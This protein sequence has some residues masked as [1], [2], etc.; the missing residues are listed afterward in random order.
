[1]LA[2]RLYLEFVIVNIG[3]S[4]GKTQAELVLKTSGCCKTLEGMHAVS[5]RTR[6]INGSR[7]QY[8]EMTTTK[9]NKTLKR[10]TDAGNRNSKAGPDGSLSE[11]I[12]EG[13]VFRTEDKVEIIRLSGRGILD[14]RGV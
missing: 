6:L 3:I 14:G 2:S 10:Q 11:A 8:I 12:S 4:E 5:R 9:G 13:R 7:N 1:L